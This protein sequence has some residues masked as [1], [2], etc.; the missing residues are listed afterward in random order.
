LSPIRD[1]N[2]T[3]PLDTFVN[4]GQYGAWWLTAGVGV[5]SEF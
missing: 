5:V 1:D 2:Q 3:A 4:W